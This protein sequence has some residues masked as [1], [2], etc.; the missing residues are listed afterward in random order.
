MTDRNFDGSDVDTSQT[1]H[2]QR[3]AEVEE[4]DGGI[5]GGDFDDPTVDPGRR[6]TAEED[7]AADMTPGDDE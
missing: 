7:L 2:E 4:S 3:V 6:P 5:T 1:E